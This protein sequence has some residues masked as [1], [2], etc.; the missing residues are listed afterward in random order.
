VTSAFEACSERVCTVD[1][2]ICGVE[3]FQRE[4]CLSTAPV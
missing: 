4:G 2:A 3:T 1:P